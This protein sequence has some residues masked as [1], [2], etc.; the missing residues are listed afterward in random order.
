MGML[1]AFG[2]LSGP[3]YRVE[4]CMFFGGRYTCKTVAAR[5]EEGAVKSGIQNACGDL[6]SGVAE[7]MNCQSTEPKS[8]K[9]LA[10]PGQ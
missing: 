6:A 10:R 7:V 9:W 1:I 8:I 2:T 3:R 5:S 4:I